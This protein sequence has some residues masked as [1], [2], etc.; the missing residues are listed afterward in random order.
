MTEKI[1]RESDLRFFQNGDLVNIREFD[2]GMTLVF[3]KIVNDEI[4]LNGKGK[5]I[6]E[7]DTI[8][9]KCEDEY[10][11]CSYCLHF[12]GKKNDYYFQHLDSADES[13]YS[14]NASLLKTEVIKIR[15]KTV[16][17]RGVYN[18]ENEIRIKPRY[19]GFQITDYGYSLWILN[20]NPSS[21]EYDGL[22]HLYIVKR[23]N[24]SK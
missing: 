2:I 12:V 24:T 1:I 18:Y 4:Q 19:A 6:E 20:D 13:L 9:R 8:L 23:P 11:G 22:Y 5:P 3:P 21:I 10:D 7:T 17:A 14:K 15:N 16:L